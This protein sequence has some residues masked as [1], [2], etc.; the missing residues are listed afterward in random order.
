MSDRQTRENR[1]RRNA[2][3]EW[4]KRLRARLR[5]RFCR[6]GREDDRFRYQGAR[7]GWRVADQE[8]EIT[9]CVRNSLCCGK[10]VLLSL[11]NR[12]DNER[13]EKYVRSNHCWFGRVSVCQSSDFDDYCGRESCE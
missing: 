9:S 7:V 12:V 13:K 10:L 6:H 3:L 11:I 4:A 1:N 5:R 8:G 2:S